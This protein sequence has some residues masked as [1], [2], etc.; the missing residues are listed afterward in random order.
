MDIKNLVIT[1]SLASTK[2]ARGFV[3]VTLRGKKKLGS[4]VSVTAHTNSRDA[5]Q[6]ALSVPFV[7]QIIGKL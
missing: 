1:I 5:F 7:G 3:F 6:S 2:T 4:L